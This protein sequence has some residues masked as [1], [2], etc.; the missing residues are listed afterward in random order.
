VAQWR[1]RNGVFFPA[2]N[3]AKLAEQARAHLRESFGCAV[4]FGRRRVIPSRPGSILSAIAR[5]REQGALL[6][7]LNAAGDLV[8]LGTETG[9]EAEGLQTLRPIVDW[10]PATLDSPSSR[11][12]ERCWHKPIP[13]FAGEARRRCGEPDTSNGPA[14]AFPRG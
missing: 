12:V 14:A 10:F 8:R 7:E 1:E 5:S 11:S 2:R 6:F 9:D 3:L 13:H 4:A